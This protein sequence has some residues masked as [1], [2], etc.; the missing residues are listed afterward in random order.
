MSIEEL[1]NAG[2]KSE[3]FT[4]EKDGACII[5]SIF[6]RF[7]EKYKKPKKDVMERFGKYMES[8][9]PQYKSEM[10]SEVMQ[11]NITKL[12]IEFIIKEWIELNSINLDENEFNL[13]VGALL[14]TLE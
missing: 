7:Y 2:V 11:I 5:S 12:T 13:A 1:R 10:K 4:R 6:N 9:I 8:K 14:K 3:I